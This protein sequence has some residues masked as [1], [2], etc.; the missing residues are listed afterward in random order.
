MPATINL[1]IFGCYIIGKP[2]LFV[3]CIWTNHKF[4]LLKCKV[5]HFNNVS[6]GGYESIRS[7]KY[8]VY[9]IGGTRGMRKVTSVSVYK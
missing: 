6:Y 9:I 2:G 1:E 7:L 8:F 3:N 5:Y 4:L